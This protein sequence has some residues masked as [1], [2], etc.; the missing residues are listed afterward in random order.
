MFFTCSPYEDT[1]QWLEIPISTKSCDDWIDI[2][3]NNFKC[4]RYLFVV[5]NTIEYKNYIVD[6][7]SNK[8]HFGSNNE[9]VVVI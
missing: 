9:Y 7:I 1:E 4:K 6:I 5:D 8:S 2:C 3:L